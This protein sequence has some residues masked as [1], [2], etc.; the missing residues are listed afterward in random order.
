MTIKLNRS[1][2]KTLFLAATAALS[3][4]LTQQATA[5]GGGTYSGYDT[6][7]DGY[8]DSNEFKPFADSRQKRSASPELWN[9]NSMDV[10]HDGKISEQEMV[11]TLME[12]LKLKRQQNP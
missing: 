6:D 7:Q 10:D 12:E 3:P 2:V 11:N 4:M 8:L 1:L 9:F 5:D